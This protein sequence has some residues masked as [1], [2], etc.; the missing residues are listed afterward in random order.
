MFDV[1]DDRSRHRPLR[2]T[3]TTAMKSASPHQSAQTAR[4]RQSSPHQQSQPSLQ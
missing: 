4:S 1:I 3:V 2:S